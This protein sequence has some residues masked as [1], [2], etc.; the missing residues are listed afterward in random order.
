MDPQSSTKR[1]EKYNFKVPGNEIP[2]WFNHQNVGSSISF[3]V[4]P[5]FPIYALCLV[6]G[7]VDD[8]FRCNVNISINGRKQHYTDTGFSELRYD[9]LLYWSPDSFR[10]CF[11]H[12]NLGDRNHVELFCKTTSYSY[13]KPNTILPKMI[14]RIGV[15]V[16]CI[17]P[18]IMKTIF[19]RCLRPNHNLCL[20]QTTSRQLLLKLKPQKLISNK[21]EKLGPTYQELQIF[22]YTS[23]LFPLSQLRGPHV[24]TEIDFKL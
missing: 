2:N 11:K 3:W 12:L 1:Y 16:E 19:Q 18:Q 5:G 14:K 4:G 10:R 23:S 20:T 13:G 7:S 24:F 9:H 8:S 17:C 22:V 21:Q 15:H 6:V